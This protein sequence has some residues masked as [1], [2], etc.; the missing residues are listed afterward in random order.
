DS[1]ALYSFTGRCCE[2]ELDAENLFTEIMSAYP[3]GKAFA[4]KGD[5]ELLG[6]Y[7]LNAH[8]DQ[9]LAIPASSNAERRQR[10]KENDA[11]LALET[12]MATHVKNDYIAVQN[13]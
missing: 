2:R 10:I 7:K 12:M 6:K 4:E 1:V 5:D 11:V 3:K 8:L 9:L 13:A